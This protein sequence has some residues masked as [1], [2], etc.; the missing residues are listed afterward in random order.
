MA[1]KQ[2][3]VVINGQEYVSKAAKE[4]K[5]G[6]SGFA[7]FMDKLK[8][9]IVP[10][11]DVTKLA[12]W[13]V[14]ALGAAFNAVKSFVVDSIAAYDEYAA[15][16][17]KLEG[18]SKLTGV[19]LRDLRDV[20]KAG[21]EGFKLSTVTANDFA[22]EI[23]KLT[24][25]AGDLSKSKDAMGAFLD[26]G[27]ARGLS[28]RDTLQAVQQAILGIDEG[29]DK[30]FGKNPSVLYKEYAD[31]MGLAV[32]KMTDQEK[33][34][35]LLDATMTGGDRVRGEYLVYLESAAGQQDLLNQRVTATKARFGEALQ[36]IRTIVL[37]GL[38]VL[39]ETLVP[40][41][42]WVG[43]AAN[44]VGVTLAEAFQTARYKIGE[45]AETIGRLTGNKDMENWGARQ[46]RSALE[47][48]AAMERLRD[49]T[50][51]SGEKVVVEL[52]K[53]ATAHE[54]V[55]TAA[56]KSAE[57]LKQEADAYFDKASQKLGAPLANLIR[58]TTTAIDELGRAG[59]DRLDPTNAEK[60]GAHMATLRAE[61]DKGNEAVKNLGKATGDAKEE[62]R[63]LAGQVTTL[64]R[65]ALQAGQAF[66][67]VDDHL[68]RALEATINLGI[69]L[70]KVFTGKADAS[71]VANAMASA[72]NLIAMMIGGD[73]ARKKLISDN[74]VA[75]ERVKKGLDAMSLDVS[76]E[77]FAK[78]QSALGSVIDTIKG[79]R[80]ARNTTDVLNALQAQGLGMSDL[81]K[82]AEQLGIRIYSDS[83]ALSVDGLKQ[84]FEAMG[85]VNMGSFG[86]DYAGQRDATLQGFDV[87]KVD[88]LG[89][90][91]QLGALGGQFSSLL[92]GVVNAQDLAGT[93][94]RLAALFDRMKAGGISATQLG[95]LTSSQ[96]LQFITDL[97]SRID[98]IAPA[99][100][101]TDGLSAGLI[102]AGGLTMPAGTVADVQAAVTVS[103][104]DLLTSANAFHDRIATA[105]EASAQHLESIDGKMTELLV[106][107]ATSVSRMDAG[108]ERLRRLADLER[109]VVAPAGA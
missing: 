99:G 108:L 7:A 12:E 30:L 97:I 56:K 17:R 102:S 45:I 83:G 76:G 60:F 31:K 77:T 78:V 96:F 80:G 82:V 74:T 50:K 101:T 62:A 86:Q 53:V 13:T 66:G 16:Q 90:L 23:A 52:G 39:L 6:L 98:Q 107:S 47:S 24:S 58:L 1:Q 28:A 3:T 32:G 106:L 70:T 92:A 18:T 37:Q 57:T 104:S 105:T 59:K 20:A 71:T 15:S 36:P 51:E 85:L 4:A 95:G 14:R 48:V 87:N 8:D 22:S 25:K 27:A 61:A 40:V 68:A 38:N 65:A 34:L 42:L 35:A 73:A 41:V 67:V 29:T 43:R 109:G 100:G 49:A 84:L 91:T 5:E 9:R 11:V 54:G 44:A 69:S 89:Q 75:L 64:A 19:A 33:A 79:G 93:R 21:E 10:V 55:A 103:V 72:A 26:I 94:T 2:V 63:D 88:A 81:K 46:Q